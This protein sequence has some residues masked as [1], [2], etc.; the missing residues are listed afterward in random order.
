MLLGVGL[1]VLAISLALFPSIKTMGQL[2]V[3]GGAMG[4]VGGL[5]TVVHFAA[6]G[7]FYGR[8]HLGRIQG[9]AQ[10]VSVLAS[11]AG[12]LF[13]AWGHETTKSYLPVYYAFAIGVFVLSL[14]AF[15]VRVPQRLIDESN[16]TGLEPD[17]ALADTPV[18]PFLQGA[19]D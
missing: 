4:F 15:A 10:I 18:S 5:I 9:V 17:L 2:W 19:K 14:A 16:R 13:L 6:W 1:L 12:P 7:H 8:G 3:Y 11:A